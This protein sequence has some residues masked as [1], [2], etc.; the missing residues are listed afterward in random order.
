[1]NLNGTTRLLA[2][3]ENIAVLAELKEVVVNTVEDLAG[4]ASK[5]GSRISAEKTEV[6]RMCCYNLRIEIWP[7]QRTS[8][9]WIPCSATTINQSTDCQ[10]FQNVLHFKADYDIANIV[11]QDQTQGS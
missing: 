1:M 7:E 2:Y 9:I 3:A 4:D 8:D 5:V 10:C 11:N 6:L